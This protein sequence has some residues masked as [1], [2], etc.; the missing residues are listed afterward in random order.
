MPSPWY[1]P[2]STRNVYNVGLGDTQSST[3]ASKERTRDIGSAV[4]AL[5][6]PISY[7]QFAPK[8]WPHS[9]S[10]LVDVAAFVGVYF[11][12]RYLIHKLSD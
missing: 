10:L 6:I 4:A 1:R 9:K 5:V 8:K 12:A 11:S 7:N 3:D 2:E